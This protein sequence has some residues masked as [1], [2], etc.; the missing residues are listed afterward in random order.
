M[1]HRVCRPLSI[2]AAGALV[3]ALLAPGLPAALAQGS[4]P[5]SSAA[6]GLVASSLPGA[7]FPVTGVAGV[8]CA[9]SSFCFAVGT[10]TALHGRTRLTSNTGLI[11]RYDGRSWRLGTRL[12][13]RQSGL[14][15]ISCVSRSFCL[16][17][18]RAGNPTGRVLAERF[19]G[20]SW[21]PVRAASPRSSGN[22]DSLGAVDCLSDSNCW[23]VGGMN[24]G[25]ASRGVSHQLVEHFN[26]RGFTLA[27]APN[28]GDALTAISCIRGNSC[29][30]LGSSGV[31]LHLAGRAWRVVRVR[32]LLHMNVGA[33]LSCR[34]LATCWIVGSHSANGDR[35]EALHFVGGRW[36]SVS[37]P[38][39]PDPDA[40]LQGLDCA[41][42]SDC[43]AVG[44]NVL[45]GPNIRPPFKMAPLAEQWNGSAWQISPVTGA[46]PTQTSG[47][48]SVSCPST[49]FC[50][51]GGQQ[52]GA[53]RSTPLFAVS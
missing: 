7:G 38:S 15:S 1:S 11:W 3:G 51:A 14:L 22:G 30:V 52:G 17:V 2:A 41:S 23:A 33:T 26:G 40:F 10:G 9:S 37:M 44:A 24:L 16:A 32:A 19:N 25:E 27:S 43:W 39:P 6:A 18:G 4:Q 42:S 29:W 8:S 47:L 36:Q 49:A 48:L 13:V 50:A 28:T 53:F 5:A 21:S 12:R 46:R 20:R 35:P 31:L 34:T 45:V